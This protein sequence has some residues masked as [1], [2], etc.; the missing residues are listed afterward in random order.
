[1]YGDV[2]SKLLSI[3]IVALVIY[4]LQVAQ[5]KF[6]PTWELDEHSNPFPKH[7][8]SAGLDAYNSPLYVGRTNIEGNLLPGTVSDNNNQQT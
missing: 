1:M 3:V 8:V 6:T 2:H 7:A 4:N 5:A